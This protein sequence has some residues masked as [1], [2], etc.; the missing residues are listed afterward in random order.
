MGAPEV[1][2]SIKRKIRA[3]FRGTLILSGGYDRLRAEADL[4]VRFSSVAIGIMDGQSPDL[5]SVVQILGDEPRAAG[6][7]R[8]RDDQGV[9]PAIAGLLLQ[10]KSVVVGVCTGRTNP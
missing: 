4:A 5:A 2:T 9:V 8:R 7:D 10:Q 1:P 3:A 6:L